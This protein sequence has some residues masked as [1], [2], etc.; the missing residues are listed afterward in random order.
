MSSFQKKTFIPGTKW[1]YLKVFKTVPN[2]YSE[3]FLT[4]YRVTLGRHKTVQSQSP[5]KSRISHKPTIIP[6]AELTAAN[7]MGVPAKEAL[8]LSHV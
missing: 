5:D 3:L 4:L 2:Y 8:S 7:H 6:A 1:L